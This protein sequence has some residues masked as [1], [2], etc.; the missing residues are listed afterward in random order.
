[1]EVVNCLIGENSSMDANLLSIINEAHLFNLVHKDKLFCYKAIK[2]PVVTKKEENP[3]EAIVD[4]ENKEKPE[5]IILPGDTEVL[6]NTN[7]FADPVNPADPVNKADSDIPVDIINPVVPV[8][9]VI[10]VIVP[11]TDIPVVNSPVD[12]VNPNPNPN[13]EQPLVDQ[14]NKLDSDEIKKEDTINEPKNILDFKYERVFP[15]PVEYHFITL[16]RKINIKQIYTVCQKSLEEAYK[17]AFS[18]EEFE[19]MQKSMKKI[20]Y[21]NKKSILKNRKNYYVD[22]YKY[23]GKFTKSD[24]LKISFSIFKY[25]NM[26]S[27]NTIVKPSEEDE[28]VSDF[29]KNIKQTTENF[30]EVLKAENRD[31]QFN[32]FDI[33]INNIEVVSMI[34]DLSL[35]DELSDYQN[36]YL[37]LNIDLIS[38]N[39]KKKF[40]NKRQSFFLRKDQNVLM[41][42]IFVVPPQ[43]W[44][45]LNFGKFIEIAEDQE[46]ATPDKI[47]NILNIVP[48]ISDKLEVRYDHLMKRPHVTKRFLYFLFENE[49]NFLYYGVFFSVILSYIVNGFMLKNIIYREI[50]IPVEKEISITIQVINYFHIAYN[51]FFLFFWL[52]YYVFLKFGFVQGNITY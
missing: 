30:L 36:S 26:I 17:E 29:L 3:T 39:I 46:D 7:T 10:P 16:L 6:V 2:A 27:M 11:S 41:R 35:G 24:Y 1:M 40:M 4:N 51:L 28:S 14:V 45:L 42:E 43:C 19:E 21:D 37:G 31:D 15:N 34:S 20:K 50:Y 52:V 9:T 5:P 38:G 48:Q 23:S 49:D 22:A 18:V 13:P 44:S 12:L 8:D 32:F 47:L 25:I 33:F